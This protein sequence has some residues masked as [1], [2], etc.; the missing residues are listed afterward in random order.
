MRLPKLLLVLAFCL[1]LSFVVYA[2]PG[3]TDSNGG[4]T[5]H[6]TGEYHYHHGYP[7]HQHYDIDGDGV[8]DCPM[9]FDDKTSS[10]GDISKTTKDSFNS[11]DETEPLSKT[12]A[13]PSIKEV[14]SQKTV[15]SETM[16]FLLIFG[17]IVGFLAVPVIVSALIGL[18]AR[19]LKRIFR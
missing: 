19:M 5:N 6:S 4:H 10:S 14:S 9:S 16:E 18:V 13:N 2:H 12:P 7:P 15:F 17:C 1:S 3:G 11:L 8:F